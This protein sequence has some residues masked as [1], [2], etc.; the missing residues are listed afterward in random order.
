MWFTNRLSI[1]KICWQ[2][3]FTVC[4]LKKYVEINVYE[5]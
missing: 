1:C 5:H 4:V 2:K 3:Y